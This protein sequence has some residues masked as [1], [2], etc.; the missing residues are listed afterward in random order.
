MAHSVGFPVFDGDNHLYETRDALTK[1]LPPEYEGAIRYVEVDG[2]TKIATLGQISDY[3]PNPTFDRVAAPG[4]QEEFFSKGN[5]DG[6]TLR[7]I[8]GKAIPSIDAFREPGPRLALLDEQG[9]DKSM[10]YPTL[11]SL[12]EERFRA[13]PEATHAIIH[14][15][16][17][18]LHE[19]WS[20]DYK[21][22]IFTAPIVTLPIVEQAIDEL[23]WVVERGAR[24]ILVRPAPASGLH[25]S[26]SF[27]L[28]EFDPFWKRVCETGVLVVMHASDSGYS[29]YSN[30]WEG[31]REFLP[32]QPAPFR[33]YY[34]LARNPAE[35]A[36]AAFACHGALTRFP[37]LRVAMVENGTN[38]V[39]RLF[40]TLSET[41]KKMP[42]LYGEH[43]LDAIRRCVYFNPFWEEDVRE[44]AELVPLDHIFYGSDYPHPEGLADPLSYVDRQRE[45]PQEDLA[46]VMGGTLSE[47]MR[48]GA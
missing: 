44:L 9:I 38:W 40:E 39:P 4:A 24:A 19:T 1:F 29:R 20:F 13:Y 34:G 26:R 18:W 12:V 2:R 11:A 41:H 46:R 21:G 30:E 7:E 37:D 36:V 28:P 5:P 25:G 23:N 8:L 10:M 15:L 16:N 35:D 47:L 48:V 31:D 17:Q 6:K 3:I 27:A 33:S 14:A 22:R 43:P 32:F 45:L 42:Q